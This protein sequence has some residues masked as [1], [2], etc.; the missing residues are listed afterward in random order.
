VEAENRAIVDVTQVFTPDAILPVQ[1]TYPPAEGW[2]QRLCLAIFD[3]ALKCLE[4]RL[5]EKRK[6]WE[7]VLSD[8]DYCFSFTTVCSVISLNAEAVRRQD[9]RGK[10]RNTEPSAPPWPSLAP[11]L[12]RAPC[13]PPSAAGG[14]FT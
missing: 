13:R 1:V 6:A 14:P 8:A 3:D 12:L 11:L 7:W 4:G 5:R 2:L 9:P 10:E